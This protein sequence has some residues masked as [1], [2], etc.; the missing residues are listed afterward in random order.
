MGISTPVT[1]ASSNTDTWPMTFV[2]SAGLGLR[3]AR[4]ASAM[5]PRQ[6]TRAENSSADGS[7]FT[8]R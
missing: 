5:A 6:A 2:M 8:A 1:E 7:G 3:F 4:M